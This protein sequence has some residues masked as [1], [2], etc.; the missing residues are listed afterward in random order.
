MRQ[1]RQAIL[2]GPLR[3]PALR[4]A[5]LRN[6]AIRK[7]LEWEHRIA[8][9][10]NNLA[11]L[12]RATLRPGDI[13]VD[14]G[15]NVG[16][17][18]RHFTAA[19]PDAS[20]HA[21]EPL[22]ELAAKLRQEFPDVAVHECALADR[23]DEVTFHRV[24]DSPG[25]SGLAVQDAVRDSRTEALTVPLRRL[26]DEIAG[27]TPRLVKIDVEGAELGVLRGAH[28]IL[29]DARPVVVFE[30][31]MLHADAYD[32]TPDQVFDE[33]HAAGYTLTALGQKQL[34]DRAAFEDVCRRSA[35]S[36]YDRTAHTNFVARP[37]T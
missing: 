34:L 28:R 3:T 23:D 17:I 25:W 16:G 27:S 1:I 36:G 14:V 13:G 33:L 18:L 15:A 20:H 2:N 24:V 32:T 9:D 5:A 22:P 37:A 31:A 10:D 30:H 35:Q 4:L 6:P 26:D 7:E 19:A 12:I 11:A 29:R 8:R 21:F